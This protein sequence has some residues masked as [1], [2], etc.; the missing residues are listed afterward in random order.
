MKYFNIADFCAVLVALVL[1]GL[2]DKFVLSKLY[3]HLEN[4]MIGEENLD[5]D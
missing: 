4:L 5:E 2:L 3:N 1:Y